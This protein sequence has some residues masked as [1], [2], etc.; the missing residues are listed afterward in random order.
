MMLYVGVF[1]IRFGFEKFE[2]RL[3]SNPIK[4]V[5]IRVDSYSSPVIEL[6]S[7]TNL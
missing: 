7:N 5:R 1:R 3:D 4:N 6:E 2:I